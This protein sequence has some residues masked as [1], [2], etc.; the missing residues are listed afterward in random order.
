MPRVGYELLTQL[1]LKNLLC[2]WERKEYPWE[3]RCFCK[4]GWVLE[5]EV[6]WC[7]KSS[8]PFTVTDQLKDEPVSISRYTAH[9][10]HCLRGQQLLELDYWLTVVKKDHHTENKW[11]AFCCSSNSMKDLTSVILRCSIMA[12]AALGTAA[13]WYFWVGPKHQEVC[14]LLNYLG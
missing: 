9:P 12:A 13:M 10:I 11:S 7:T 1:P 5:F 2:V 14:I 6:K 4:H 3:N 8:D